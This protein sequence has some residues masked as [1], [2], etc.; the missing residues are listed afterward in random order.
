[1]TVGEV[2]FL[3]SGNYYNKTG[4]FPAWK[5]PGREPVDVFQ[6][7]ENIDRSNDGKFSG[8]EAAK[9]FGKGV[10]SPVTSMFSSAAN[11]AIGAGALA[12]STV[13]FFAIGGS[14]A[15]LLVTAGIVMGAV[16]AGTAIH[17]AVKAK[18]GDDK[19]KV[20]FDAGEA[21]SSIGLSV[22]GARAALKL[23]GISTERLNLFSAT[24]KCIKLSPKA[25][26]T[27]YDTFTTG[28]WKTNLFNALKPLLCRDKFY[29]HARALNKEARVQIN[30][31]IQEIKS[32]LP[33]EMRDLVIGRPK[34]CPSIQARLHKVF[35]R[36]SP[37]MQSKMDDLDFVRK[38]VN[39]SAGTRLVLKDTS[40]ASIDKLVGSIAKAI[41]TGKIHVT[42]IDNYRA[43]Q[44]YPYFSDEHIALLKAASKKVGRELIV[45]SMNAKK[46]GYTAVQ[47][48]IKHKNGALGEF[49]IHGKPTNEIY[50]PEHVIHNIRQM[51]DVSQEIPE[52]GRLYG[53]IK[54]VMQSMNDVQNEKFNGYLVNL[55]K[56]SRQREMGLKSVMPEFPEGLNEVVNFKNLKQLYQKSKLIKEGEKVK[57]YVLPRYIGSVEN[58][59]VDI[60]DDYYQKKVNI[61]S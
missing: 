14:A 21:T 4:S 28:A 24:G 15:P 52:L 38:L 37:E 18:N 3:V 58:G 19:E 20:F 57:K 30:G 39:D 27:S 54:F 50:K 9:N 61:V 53:P 42:K 12:A 5:N 47:I 22:S 32:I 45:E 55:Y 11:F 43:P 51:K 59:T 40:P 26:K 13:L 44:G 49:Q 35:K 17:K 2:K 36:L 10:I 31:A 16:Q 25:L 23:A 1:M 34:A 60:A 6:K 48:N 29:L 33:E 7:R 56:F 41:E 8:K 46:S